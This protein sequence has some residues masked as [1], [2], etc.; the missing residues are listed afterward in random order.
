MIDPQEQANRWI[1]KLE[2]KNGMKIVKQTE[3][4]FARSVEMSVRNGT[5]LIIEDAGEILDPTLDPILEK[6]LIPQGA[7][8]F[9]I[10]MGDQDVDYDT[11]FR[12][13]ITTKIPN[14]HYLPEISIKTTLINFT[15]TTQGLEEQLLADVVKKEQPKI[16]KRK[17]ELMIAMAKDQ[18]SLKQAED[19]I[20]SSLTDSKGNILD[21]PEIIETLKSSKTLSNEIGQRMVRAEEIKKEVE[22]AFQQYQS[23]AARGTILYFVIA[24]LS[25][26][27]PMY[28]YSLTYFTRLFNKV[29]D[30]SQKSDVIADRILILINSI[31]EFIFMNVCRGLFNA[32]KLIFSFLISVQILRRDGK[33]NDAEWNLLLKG[34]SIIPSS[35]VRTSNPDT[36]KFTDKTWDTINFVQN[37]SAPFKEPIIGPEISK[38][39]QIWID[40]ASKS[41]PQ[42]ELF[43]EPYNDVSTF[44]KLLLIKAFREE[45]IIYMIIK[46]VTEH[47]GRKFVEVPPISMEE[48]YA[49][50]N[51]RNPIIFVLS[52]GADPMSMMKRLAEMMGFAEKLEII[53]LGKGQGERAKRLIES[54]FKS[55]KWIV[56][57]NCHLAKS[58]MHDLENI[59]EN[60]EDPKVNMN[61]EFRL[62]LTSMPCDYFP[63]PVLQN[64]VKLTNEP[65]KGIRANLTRSLNAITEDS[66]ESCVR[67]H[68]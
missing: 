34:V 33:V 44:H 61:E 24:D 51:C 56:L 67:L 16:E 22:S 9:S 10:R 32:H 37:V 54:G 29:I 43:P 18:K 64:G 63:V 7:G 26:I 40:W 42:D 49:D 66:F 65:P 3:R 12:M 30:V 23:V 1:K 39:K 4:D 15:V 8:R 50:T 62:F 48:V 52:Q 58:W 68:E 53:S 55:G 35:F 45:K 60:F 17:T 19:T 20:L 13:Y 27:D 5:C 21:D 31:T 59:V 46:F 2:E 38:N 11:N 36:V 57:Q 6:N 47:L 14:P 41:E 28:Q 25:L